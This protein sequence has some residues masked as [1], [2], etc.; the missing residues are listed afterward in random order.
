MFN[1]NLK[2]QLVSFLFSSSQ[3]NTKMTMVL[4]T[5]DPRFVNFSKIQKLYNVAIQMNS[6]LNFVILLVRDTPGCI[7]IC[8]INERSYNGAR[9]KLAK[10]QYFKDVLLNI[11]AKF[12]FIILK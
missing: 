10:Q 11:L 1:I 3:H 8:R 5:I 4:K 6:I 2:K 7:F 9:L 12:C